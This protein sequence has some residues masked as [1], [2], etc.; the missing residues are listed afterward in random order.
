MITYHKNLNFLFTGAQVYDIK[1]NILLQ[2]N[3]SEINLDKKGKKSCTGNSI[4]IDT[5]K[6]FSKDNIESNKMSI[7]YCITEHM[8]A[9][10]L[11]NPY[12]GPCSRNFV[13]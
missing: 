7:A 3:Q 12:K 9:N 8:I 1:Q 2:D 6:F 5:L 10:V 4:H 13:T 11:L